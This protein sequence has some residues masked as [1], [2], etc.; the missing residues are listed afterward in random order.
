MPEPKLFYP[1]TITQTEMRNI[2][3]SAI[4][5]YLRLVKTS[6]R[7]EIAGHLQ[8]SLPSVARI[9]EQLIASGL[10]RATGQKEP[11][12]GRGRELLELNTSENLI[13]GIDMGGSHICGALIDLGGRVLHEYGDLV[14]WGSAEKNYRHLVGFLQTIIEQSKRV[15]GRLLGIAIGVPA[16]LDSRTGM[17]K[18]AP[19]LDWK[20]FA[21]LHRLEQVFDLPVY[22]ENDVNLAALGEHW[23]G[24]GQGAR[25]L[26]MIAIGTGIGAGIILDNNLYRGFSEAAGE[27]GYILPDIDSLD[28]KYPGFGALESVASG[29]GISEQAIKKWNVL[30]RTTKTPG[31]EAT[32]VFEAARKGHEWARQV[33]SETI[34]YL[35]LALAN[36]I[37]CLDPELIILG[38]GIAGSASMLIEPIRKRLSGV[39][40]RVPRIEESKLNSRAS[41]LGA[42]VRVFQKYIEYSA[43]HYE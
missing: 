3:R 14:L 10:V 9:I 6:S 1:H 35:S 32:D 2:N 19:A 43:V 4:V 18:V 37:A 20:D 23:F 34:D 16:I 36:V 13:I 5:E 30:H 33:V 42:V 22:L 26:V 17:I 7:T 28:R 38:G 39:I 31:M 27:I 12:R 29:K 21:L 8:L 15:H 40:P 24:A 11:S 41:L 25:D